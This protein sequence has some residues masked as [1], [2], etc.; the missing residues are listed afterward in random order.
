LDK[1]F[2]KSIIIE[3]LEHSQQITTNERET[4][5]TYYPWSSTQ[6]QLR[7]MQALHALSD[8]TREEKKQ[9]RQSAGKS[10]KEAMRTITEIVEAKRGGDYLTAC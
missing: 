2:H 8:L 10:Y 1:E 3:G 6:K 5:E 7:P 4:M 9:V